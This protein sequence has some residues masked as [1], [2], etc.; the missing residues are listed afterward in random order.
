MDLMFPGFQMSHRLN[1]AY[2]DYITVFIRNTED[3]V[4]FISSLKMF[5]KATTAKVNWEKCV[6]LLLG[7]WQNMGLSAPTTM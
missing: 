5:Q 1:T 2:A 6:S 7:E 4:A 3:R